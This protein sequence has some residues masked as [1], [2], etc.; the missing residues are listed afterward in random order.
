[1]EHL[2][3]TRPELAAIRAAYMEC[4]ES[5]REQRA[6]NEVARARLRTIA[7]LPSTLINYRKRNEELEGM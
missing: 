1:M 7:A 6:E 5:L 3:S 4:I 2:A